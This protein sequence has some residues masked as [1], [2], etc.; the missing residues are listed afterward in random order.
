M[1]TSQRILFRCSCFVSMTRSPYCGPWALGVY[2]QN[3]LQICLSPYANPPR[4]LDPVGIYWQ[5]QNYVDLYLPFGLRSAPFLFNGI[6]DALKW[7]LKQNY[8]LRHV[9]HILDEFH[10]VQKIIAWGALFLFLR[11]LCPFGFQPSPL[12]PWGSHKS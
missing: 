11:C 12:R 3:G 5:S 1:T 6:S 8:G 9:I 4:R 7:I 10:S 2:G